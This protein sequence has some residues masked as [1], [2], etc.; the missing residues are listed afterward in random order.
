M[1]KEQRLEYIFGDRPGDYITN[2]FGWLNALLSDIRT[3]IDGGQGFVNGKIEPTLKGSHG[4]GNVSIPILVCTG[5]ELASALYTG[6][7]YNAT[8]NVKKFIEEFFP[9]DLKKIPQILWDGIRN[10]TTHV[11]IP[12]TIRVSRTHVQF[13]F[14]VDQSS[15][16]PSSVTKS[17]LNITIYVNSIQFYHILKRSIDKYR[18]KLKTDNKLQLDFITAWECK[19]KPHVKKTSDLLIRTEVEY[20]L[21]RLRKPNQSNLLV[22]ES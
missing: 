13:S 19:Q 9:A 10:G 11:F 4:A 15:D 22:T 18:S 8:D 3:L 14:F 5:L 6:N 2:R 1:N 17:G 16:K 21:K 12:N 20:L 7:R